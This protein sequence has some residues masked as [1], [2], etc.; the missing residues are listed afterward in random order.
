[1]IATLFNAQVS[2]KWLLL[3]VYYSLNI[4]L[5]DSRVCVCVLYLSTRV[6]YKWKDGMRPSPLKPYVCLLLLRCILLGLSTSHRENR[7][8][9]I[10]FCLFGERKRFWSIQTKLHTTYGLY[11]YCS[12]FFCFFLKKALLPPPQMNIQVPTYLQVLKKRG[13][14]NG[15]HFDFEACFSLDGFLSKGWRWLAGTCCIRRCHSFSKLA[16]KK[17]QVLTGSSCL[18]H[19]LTHTNSP[20][21]ARVYMLTGNVKLRTED[22]DYLFAHQ[23]FFFYVAA[24]LCAECV[25]VYVMCV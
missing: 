9:C 2:R 22:W 1:M 6:F 7:D 12:L 11:I 15:S 16:K 19:L 24:H 21:L 8:Y 13:R 20:A 4:N 5:N 25:C 17:E 23:S 18:S 3:S 10:A 14:A